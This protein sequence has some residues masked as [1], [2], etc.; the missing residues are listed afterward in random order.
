VKLGKI[1][2]SATLCRPTF[3]STAR[4]AF[5]DMPSNTLFEFAYVARSA[6]PHGEQCSMNILRIVTSSS[7]D[8]DNLTLFFPLQDGAWT[9]SKFS[10]YFQGHRSLPVCCDLRLSEWHNLILL[11]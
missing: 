6:G 5:L 2:T 8:N 1:E 3:V 11:W 4:M 10:A 9:D 7:S